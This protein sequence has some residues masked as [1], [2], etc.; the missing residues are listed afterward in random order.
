MQTRHVQYAKVFRGDILKNPELIDN[1][2]QTQGGGDRP[3]AAA[4][5]K[6][7]EILTEDGDI[8]VDLISS[9]AR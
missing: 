3:M 7:G 6:R 5:S 2:L 8:G 4:A 9:G 1:N